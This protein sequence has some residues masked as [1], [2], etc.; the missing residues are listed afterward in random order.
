MAVE[1][2][3]SEKKWDTFWRLNLRRTRFEEKSQAFR[4]RW[5]CFEILKQV[6]AEGIKLETINQGVFKPWE[7][8][9][10]PGEGAERLYLVPAPVRG[11]V[12]QLQGVAQV[13]LL[14]TP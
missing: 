8:V 4:F 14:L 7:E 2:D 5:V 10:S 6:K 13:S 11:E 9:L 3:Q 1:L 12:L